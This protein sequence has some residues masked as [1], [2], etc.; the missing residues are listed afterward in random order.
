MIPYMSQQYNIIYYILSIPLQIYNTLNINVEKSIY[1]NYK[2]YYSIVQ[3][4]GTI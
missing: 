2:L 3:I 1:I 4:N